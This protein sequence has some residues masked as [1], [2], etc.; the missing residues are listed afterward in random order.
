MGSGFQNFNIFKL[1]LFFHI[2]ELGI[3]LH[4]NISVIEVLEA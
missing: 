2:A 1:Y 3:Y 4:G